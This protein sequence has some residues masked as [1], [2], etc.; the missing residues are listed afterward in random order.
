VLT[1]LRA[2]GNAKM[3]G[4]PCTLAGLLTLAIERSAAQA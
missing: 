2:W 1:K 3:Q 4:K